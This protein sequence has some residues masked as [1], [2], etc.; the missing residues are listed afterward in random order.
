MADADRI[1]VT[2]NHLV[3]VVLTITPPDNE[4][5]ANMMKYTTEGGNAYTLLSH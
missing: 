1:G 3:G 2:K 4:Q 5:I